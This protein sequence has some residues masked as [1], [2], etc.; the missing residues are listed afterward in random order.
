MIDS[1]TYLDALRIKDQYTK[2]PSA[3][4]LAQAF[5]E[6]RNEILGVRSRLVKEMEAYRPWIRIHPFNINF[7]KVDPRTRC[8]NEIDKF[9]NFTREETGNVDRITDADIQ[10]AKLVPI[11]QLYTFQGRGKNSLCPFHTEK[12][13]SFHIYKDSNKFKCFGCGVNG[14]SIDFIIKLKGLSFVK[15]VEELR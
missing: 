6:N 15:A 12:T 3:W 5:K 1:N 8:V 4:E 2:T 13:G 11:E 14:D 9:L 10:R 7:M